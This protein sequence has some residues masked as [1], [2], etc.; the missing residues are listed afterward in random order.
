MSLFPKARIARREI[1][2]AEYIPYRA[3]VAP[4]IVCTENG[5]FVQVLKVAG[6]SFESEDDARLNSGTNG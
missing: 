4:G 2:A 3:H 5:D 6:A 1:S